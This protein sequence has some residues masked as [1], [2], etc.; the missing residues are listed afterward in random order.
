MIQW[1]LAI[2]SWFLCLF[3]IQLVHLE[4]LGSH[5][6]DAYISPFYSR[7]FSE[8]ITDQQSGFQFQWL[9]IPHCQE[10]PF[11]GVVSYMRGK[12]HRLKTYQGHI[13]AIRKVRRENSHVPFIKSPYV[14]KIVDT[15][16]L[17]CHQKCLVKSF[18]QASSRYF[19]KT[20]S[21]DLTCI[22]SGSLYFQVAKWRTGPVRVQYFL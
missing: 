22:S 9:L 4:V 20:V 13:Q 21:L 10:R 12:M 14:T 16:D 17:L 6:V 15:G 11:L 2:W 18:Q 7:S 3:K 19:G 5:T 1:K 8:N